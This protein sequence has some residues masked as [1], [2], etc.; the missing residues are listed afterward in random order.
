MLMLP[1]AAS[2]RNTAP[3]TSSPNAVGESRIDQQPE[4]V[5]G[6]RRA[7]TECGTDGLV[8]AFAPA[9]VAGKVPN[10]YDA[11]RTATSSLLRNQ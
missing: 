10:A 7:G 9:E 1:P 11:Q 3:L 6:D 5:P 2:P 8:L 4:A